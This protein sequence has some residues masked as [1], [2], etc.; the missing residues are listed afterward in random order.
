MRYTVDQ[1]HQSCRLLYLLSALYTHT[2]K[3]LPSLVLS[4]SCPGAF[5]SKGPAVAVLVLNTTNMT[6]LCL[7]M[8]WYV[9]YWLRNELRYCLASFTNCKIINIML[10]SV[11]LLTTDVNQ[12]LKYFTCPGPAPSL[13]CNRLRLPGASHDALSSSLLLPLSLYPSIYIH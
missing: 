4:S 13:C 5:Q 11:L 9:I 8:N 2:V 3:L 12:Q 1:E 6:I 7:L 10:Q